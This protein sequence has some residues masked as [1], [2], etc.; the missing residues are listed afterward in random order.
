MEQ[1]GFA[2]AVPDVERRALGTHELEKKVCASPKCH[3]IDVNPEI[4]R[5]GL[6]DPTYTVDGVHLNDAGYRILAAHVKAGIAT[7]G[8]GSLQASQFLIG[9]SFRRNPH[10]T[11]VA[12]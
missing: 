1:R 9:P 5:N 11:L 7:A 10:D 4:G 2:I 8:A 3:L 6:I 12:G